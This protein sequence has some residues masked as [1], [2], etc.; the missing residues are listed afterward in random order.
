M[1]YIR[2]SK[3]HKSRWVPLSVSVTRELRKYL[4]KRRQKNLPMAPKAFLM[5]SHPRSPEAYSATR[6][7]VFV[8]SGERQRRCLECTGT[9]TAPS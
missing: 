7:G 5:W 4:Q 8:A 6:L 9:P 1:L 3:F 2:L